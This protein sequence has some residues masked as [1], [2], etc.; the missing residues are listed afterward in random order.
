[1]TLLR[2]ATLVVADLAATCTRYA[3]WLGYSVVESGAIPAD[4]AA[5]W[6]APASAGRSYAVMQPASGE[7]VYLR[8]VE[9][10]PVAD[11]QPIRTY[12][13][14]ATEIC[15]T[16]VDAVH[17]R[18]LASPFEVIGPPRTLDGYATIKPMQVRGPDVEIVYLTEFAGHDPALVLPQPKTL[19]DRPFIIVHASKDIQAGLGW[20]RDVV[21]L[22]AIEPVSIR[23]T[24]IERAFGL[25]PEDK[26]A[27]TT[28]QWPGGETFLEFD[29]YPAVA[30]E[31][32]RHAGALPPGVAV[33]TMLH[34]DIARLEGHWLSPPVRREG[35]LYEGRAVGVLQTP[36]G[37]L[38]EVID[39]A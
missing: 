2:C 26:T 34:P 23:Y 37:A 11:Y 29:Q 15:V 10:D 8:F 4:L 9:G 20:L 13:W 30:T 32:P 21:G 5:A 14:A 33:V 31:R 17:Q 36:E 19:V 6:N 3:E 12:G 28:A 22:A 35:P 24:M 38:L 27:I 25:S 18:M 1:M 7:A 16:D 39:A